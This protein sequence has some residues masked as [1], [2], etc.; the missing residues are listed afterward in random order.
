MG[1]DV[2][3]HDPYVTD[4]NAAQHGEAERLLKVEPDLDHATRDADVVV[5]LQAHKEYLSGALDGVRVFDTRGAL[6]GDT[7]ERL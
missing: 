7:V 5:L 1:A 4:W 2:R 3:F 6:S